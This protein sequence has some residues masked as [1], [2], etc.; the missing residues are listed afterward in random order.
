MTSAGSRRPAMTCTT[1][2]YAASGGAHR[3]LSLYFERTSAGV[4]LLGAMRVTH[5]LAS[6]WTLWDVNCL[7]LARCMYISTQGEQALCRHGR[8]DQQ[9]RSIPYSAGVA[10]RPEASG[11]AW[12]ICG[13]KG[14]LVLVGSVHC[15]VRAIGPLPAQG[16]ARENLGRRPASGQRCRLRDSN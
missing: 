3:V 7:Q 12:Q 5:T 9:Q 14:K 6:C 4:N 11:M 15:P 8:V 13:E 16:T 10:Q 2:L 1:Y